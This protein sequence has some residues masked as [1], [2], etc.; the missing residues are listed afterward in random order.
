MSS[1]VFPIQAILFSYLYFAGA[2]SAAYQE[3]VKYKNTINKLLVSKFGRSARFKLSPGEIRGL[4]GDCSINFSY[5]DDT[6][7][8]L[9]P[10]NDCYIGLVT[11]SYGGG[12][13]DI[14]ER[15]AKLVRAG[16]DMIC[17]ANR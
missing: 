11:N 15:A 13:R 1:M 4:G 8:L 7:F 3:L 14:L 2:D 5:F 6:V 9:S 12:V 17:E 16:E 10:I